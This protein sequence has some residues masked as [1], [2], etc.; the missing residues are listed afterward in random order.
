MSNQGPL[1]ST[2]MAKS[3]SIYGFLVILPTYLAGKTG[4][5][6][7]LERDVSVGLFEG[8]VL[9]LSDDYRFLTR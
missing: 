2:Y 9:D 5:K 7:F 4:E 3:G 6:Y 8:R 1:W